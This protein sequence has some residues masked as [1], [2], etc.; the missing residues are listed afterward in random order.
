MTFVVTPLVESV[1][2]FQSV[3]PAEGAACH[4]EALGAKPEATERR[5]PRK[6]RVDGIPNSSF[7][8][9]HSKSPKPH[10]AIRS[11]SPNFEIELL[12]YTAGP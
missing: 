2:G 4:G 1:E 9:P 7:L 6:G 10:P 12:Y 3:I 11:Q 5:D 8:I